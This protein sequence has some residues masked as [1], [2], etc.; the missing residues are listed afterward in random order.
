MKM[1]ESGEWIRSDKT[2]YF[3]CSRKFKVLDEMLIRLQR[4]IKNSQEPRSLWIKAQ[5][6]VKFIK[7]LVRDLDLLHKLQLRSSKGRKVKNSYAKEGQTRDFK[8]KYSSSCCKDA[9]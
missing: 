8:D 9:Y 5:Y 2:L 1:I 3:E 7:T 6:L 4:I